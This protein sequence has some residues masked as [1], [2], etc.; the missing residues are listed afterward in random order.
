MRFLNCV[1]AG[2]GNPFCHRNTEALM[3][4]LNGADVEY[5]LILSEIMKKQEEIEMII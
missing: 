4:S 5:H 2:E 1:E 3:E